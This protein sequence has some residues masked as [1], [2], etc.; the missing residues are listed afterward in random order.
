MNHVLGSFIIIYAYAIDCGQ[1]AL[2][3][4][5]DQDPGISLENKA[6]ALRKDELNRRYPS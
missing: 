4:A 5:E 6:A 1:F 2:K 3:F